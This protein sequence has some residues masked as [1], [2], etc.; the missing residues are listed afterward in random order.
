MLFASTKFGFI[1]LVDHVNCSSPLLRDNFQKLT[2]WALAF[3]PKISSFLSLY[4]G[5]FI[6]S[7]NLIKPNFYGPLPHWCSTN[8]SLETNPLY[9]FA[10]CL[11]QLCIFN[12]IVP[13]QLLSTQDGTVYILFPL[14]LQTSNDDLFIFTVIQC[15]SMLPATNYKYLKTWHGCKYH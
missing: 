7:T 11:V 2:F 4:G 10:A 15:G 14:Q 5:H 9:L 1:N 13:F 12:I 6:L 8:V 3:H